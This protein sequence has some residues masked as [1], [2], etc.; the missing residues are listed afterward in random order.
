MA[1]SAMAVGLASVFNKKKNTSTLNHQF[2]HVSYFGPSEQQN[3]GLQ[4]GINNFAKSFLSVSIQIDIAV[5]NGGVV[6]W[7]I[8]DSVD[9][10]A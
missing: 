4:L 2:N 7:W 9:P 3:L 6:V 8:G 5:A 1:H 10:N